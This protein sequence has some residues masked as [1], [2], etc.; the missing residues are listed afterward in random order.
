MLESEPIFEAH[1]MKVG[2]GWCVLVI[3]PDD[4]VDQV[5]GFNTGVAA[6][7]WIQDESPGWLE[8]HRVTHA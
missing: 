7:R 5:V 6:Y 1:P 3:W 8:Q 4:K 2:G